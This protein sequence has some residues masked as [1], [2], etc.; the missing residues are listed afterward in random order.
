M[1]K[2]A[3]GKTDKGKN[4]LNIEDLALD[5][6]EEVVNGFNERNKKEKVN[7]SALGKKE[8]NLAILANLPLESVE[9]L[10]VIVT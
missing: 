8:Q 1:S 4:E 5:K 9:E 2:I 3:E 7:W 6:L 10:Q